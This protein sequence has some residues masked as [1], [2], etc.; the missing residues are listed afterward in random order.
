LAGKLIK[1][2]R[3]MSS[4]CTVRHGK[5]HW[6]VFK[7]PAEKMERK[8]KRKGKEFNGKRCTGSRQ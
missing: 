4:R 2:R 6:W 8:R 1:P 5:G 7:C 3:F